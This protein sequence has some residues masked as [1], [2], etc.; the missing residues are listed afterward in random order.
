MM[1]SVLKEPDPKLRFK[2]QP[3][4]KVD[5]DIRQLMDDMLETMYQNDGIGLAAPQVGVSKRVVVLD[6]NAGTDE[7]PNIYFMAN[8][9]ILTVSDETSVRN[10]GCLSVPEVQAEVSRPA[11][12]RIRYLN[13]DNCSVEADVDG[14]FATCVQHE[15]DH[16][17]GVLF[18]DH[19]SKLKQELIQKKL[20]KIKKFQAA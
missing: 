6:L 8:P 4:E 12:V 5:D 18:I 14:L 17:N 20:K 19:L 7:K 11:R 13:R 15:I 9:E 10:E 16:L 1:L 2:A 3:V